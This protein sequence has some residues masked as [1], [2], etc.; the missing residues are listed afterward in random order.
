MAVYI[1]N[2]N[3]K[4]GRMIMCHMIADTKEELFEMVDKIGIQRRWCHNGDHF[5][6][7]KS[8]KKL[9]VQNGA[10]ELSVIDLARKSLEI[11]GIKR[12][13]KDN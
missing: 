13:K 3:A 8:K 1:D 5:D 11:N 9:A 2:Y 7:C 10:I 4:F 6:V 12:T